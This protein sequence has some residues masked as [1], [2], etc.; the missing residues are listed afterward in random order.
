MGGVLF[1][2]YLREVNEECTQE[3]SKGTTDEE[4]V[5]GI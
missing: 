4:Y 2:R 1:L 3:E 5:R